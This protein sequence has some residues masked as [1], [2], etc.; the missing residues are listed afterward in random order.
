MHE[1]LQHSTV[2]T[3][4]S[5]RDFFFPQQEGFARVFCTPLFVNSMMTMRDQFCTEDKRRV[6]GFFLE[7]NTE[8]F[9]WTPGLD[10]SW[11]HMKPQCPWSTIQ[12]A[13][14]ERP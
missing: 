9:C 3:V 11:C 8:W 12:T 13:P 6:G 2:V 14:L 10:L 1:I 5:I 4:Q 7:K